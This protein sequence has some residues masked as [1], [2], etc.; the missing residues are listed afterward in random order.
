M[1]QNIL[2]HYGNNLHKE[3]YNNLILENNYF[4]EFL[5]V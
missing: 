2:K 3:K 4:C 1:I 5:F